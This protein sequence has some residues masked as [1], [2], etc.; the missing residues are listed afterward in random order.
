MR[1]TKYTAINYPH[2]SF[3]HAYEQLVEKANGRQKHLRNLYHL[4]CIKVND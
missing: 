3:F 2:D 4:C 1:G